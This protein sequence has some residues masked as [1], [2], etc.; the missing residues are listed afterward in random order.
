M[1]TPEGGVSGGAGGGAASP[2]RERLRGKAAWELGV[3]GFFAVV[4]LIVL[5]ESRDLPPGTFEPLGS[6][7]VPRTVAVLILLLSLWVG[8]RALR[9][10]AA[11][12]E[13]P[14]Y[15]PR[16]LD[17]WVV[18]GLTVLYAFAMQGRWLGFA[19]L[20]AL[21]LIAAIGWLVR[22]R[23]RVMPWV[24]L[25]AAA[26]GWGCAYVFTRVFVVDLPGL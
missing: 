21:F 5:W 11:E 18:C 7:P 1:T 23:A 15:E 4:C 10:P 8:F 2:L 25:V 12:P 16:P 17:A 20:T 26:I 9:R 24:V 13:D 6:G 22:F 14:G 3:A 19:P